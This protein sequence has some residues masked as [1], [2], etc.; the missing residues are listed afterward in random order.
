MI[1]FFVHFISHLLVEHDDFL[2]SILPIS[3]AG[4]LNI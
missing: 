3:R 4:H 2:K 1:I